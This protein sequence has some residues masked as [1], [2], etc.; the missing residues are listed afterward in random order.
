MLYDMELKW[1]FELFFLP[2]NN[3]YGLSE[4]NRIWKCL[5]HETLKVTRTY[6]GPTSLK[7]TLVKPEAND[8][9]RYS[10]AGKA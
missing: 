9:E 10:Q 1:K 3:N 8:V 2:L 7:V 4:L 6:N 5:S